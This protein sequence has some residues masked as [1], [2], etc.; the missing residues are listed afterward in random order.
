[1]RD[2]YAFIAAALAVC[3][4]TAHAQPFTLVVLPDTQNYVDINKPAA[5]FQNFLAQTTWIR[6]EVLGDNRRNIAFVT[7]VG[8]IVQRGNRTAEW[9]KADQAMSL[10][11]GVV[12]WSILPGNHDW[13]VT[14]DK[15]S[16]IE[17]YR[18][19]FPP[20]RFDRERWF[21]GASPNGLNTYQ[22]F[23]WQGDEY[24]HLAI[25]WNPPSIN[26]GPGTALAWA[27]SVLDQFPTTPAI[28]STHEYVDDDLRRDPIG[29][30]MWDE[31]IRSNP[32]VFLV[33]NGH[34]CTSSYGS[35]AGEYHQTS[36][37]QFGDTVHELLQ[38]FQCLPNGGDAW[39]RLIEID[40]AEG[41]ISVETYSPA[42]DNFQTEDI[43]DDGPRAS[44]F[45]LP[46]N[47]TTRFKCSNDDLSGDGT[48]D[49]QD[50]LLFLDLLVQGDRDADLN[51]DREHNFF[52]LLLFL[53]IVD[54][55]CP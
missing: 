43:F 36:V 53:E 14:G 52:D 25:E 42:L 35:G 20:S 1:M 26:D 22:V 33:L 39:L 4:L 27:Q 41:E 51:L 37:N 32:Q 50:A 12:P 40:K 17:N 10:L 2:R 48:L 34:F 7:H 3:S 18:S 23:D 46:V 28:I 6:D 9:D 44:R 24:L 16:G 21:G 30:R 8:D 49:G 31:L 45:T 13:N 19:Y 54:Q 47:L 5:N 29:D 15:N 55:G 38:D 11:D